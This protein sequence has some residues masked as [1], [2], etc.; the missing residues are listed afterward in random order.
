MLQEAFQHLKSLVES[1]VRQTKDE[2][3]NPQIS[4]QELAALTKQL[5]G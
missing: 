5:Y 2:Y 1:L 4:N 3:V